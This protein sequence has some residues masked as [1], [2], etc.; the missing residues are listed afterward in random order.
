MAGFY[1]LVNTVLALQGIINWEANAFRNPVMGEQQCF[2]SF[3]I[4][5]LA[6]AFK[7]NFKSRCAL[8]L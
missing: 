8:F 5:I 6:F 4:T 2:K 1:K 7:Q 3:V